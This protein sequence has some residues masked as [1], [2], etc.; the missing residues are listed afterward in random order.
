MVDVVYGEWYAKVVAGT[1]NVPKEAAVID[2]STELRD[3]NLVAF[4]SYLLH[5]KMKFDAVL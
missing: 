5:A 4:L 1:E 3:R 2:S